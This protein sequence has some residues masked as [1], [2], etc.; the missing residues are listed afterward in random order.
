MYTIEPENEQN[1]AT[2]TSPEAKEPAFH[3][4]F[5][6]ITFLVLPFMWALSVPAIVFSH[7]AKAL[8]TSGNIELSEKFAEK[9]RRFLISAWAISSVMLLSVV[10]LWVIIH[11]S[12][13]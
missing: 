11:L 4:L 5:A 2:A 3:S 10:V 7:E 1:T 12:L 13:I 9:A 6:I 8:Y